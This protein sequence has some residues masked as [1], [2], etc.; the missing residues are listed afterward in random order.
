MS[1]RRLYR[2]LLGRLVP[3]RVQTR[4]FIDGLREDCVPAGLCVDVGAGSSPFA[5]ALGEALPDARYV[6]V[7]LV[8]GDGVEVVC[9]AAGLP[10]PDGSAGLVT[11]FQVVQHL[12]CVA[13]ALADMRRVLAPGGCV[14]ISY[15]AL[16]LQGRDCDLWRWTRAGME[17]QLTRAGFAVVR[18]DVRGG[19]L[20]SATS[21]VAGLPGRLLVGGTGWRRATGRGGALRLA[22]AFAL[23]LPFHLLGFAAAF[24][25]SLLGASP[26]YV[27]GII[28]ARKPADG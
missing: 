6:A 8:R 11:L 12:P 22:L 1:G 3:E 20:L 5:A 4:R 28:L 19:L 21:L 13:D 17:T 23:A 7:D 25:D 24:A 16:Q 2:F 14:L 10:F 15:P 27:G 9:D 26:V 18:H